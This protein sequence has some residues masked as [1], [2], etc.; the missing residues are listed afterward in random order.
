MALDDTLQKLM[1]VILNGWPE[2]KTRIDQNLVPCFHH[3]NELLVEDG[4]LFKGNRCVVP[5][6]MCKPMLEKLHN[7]HMGMES[8]LRY[9][10]DSVFWPGLNGEPKDLIRREIC[11]SQCNGPV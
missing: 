7:A 4:L 10:R 6:A 2:S 1:Q 5:Q 3:R 11:C 9:A 8:S